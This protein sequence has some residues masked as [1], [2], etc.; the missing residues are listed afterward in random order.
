MPFASIAVPEY[1]V[2]LPTDYNAAENTQ[3]KQFLPAGHSPLVNIKTKTPK[4]AQLDPV[5]Q[6][7]RVAANFDS[8]MI[9]SEETENMKRM[10]VDED[11]KLSRKSNKQQLLH[12]IIE[13]FNE[14]PDKEMLMDKFG[15]DSRDDLIMD[16]MT[17]D[18]EMMQQ[19]DEPSD[20]E[21]PAMESSSSG[22][23]GSGSG[24]SRATM[25]TTVSSGSSSDSGSGNSM[26]VGGK[27]PR[28]RPRKQPWEKAPRKRPVGK[29]VIKAI[30]QREEAMR[31]NDIFIVYRETVDPKDLMDTKPET[32]GV[33]VNEKEANEKLLEFL[34]VW[35]P[36]PEFEDKLK[37]GK[38]GK[39]INEDTGCMDVWLNENGRYF[40]GEALHYYVEKQ[41]IAK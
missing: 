34:V 35:P 10:K 36:I 16:E 27:R 17:E 19:D 12:K 2:T 6:K 23:S 26:N 37:R 21:E 22:S 39:L 33:F 14:K 24:V 13:Q 40:G 11:T 7:K 1:F 4:S 32:I 41:R 5:T 8:P 18:E 9:K 31:G 25:S 30:K 3:S 29:R 15:Y 28:G 20:E 38:A